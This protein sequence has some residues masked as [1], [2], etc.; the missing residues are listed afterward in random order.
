MVKPGGTGAYLAI[1]ARLAPL[2]PRGTRRLGRVAIGFLPKF[3][4]VLGFLA[5]EVWY[6]FW[7][8]DVRYLH[9]G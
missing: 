4:R 6:G 7:N 8:R 2:P 1:P 5:H 3:V 9:R